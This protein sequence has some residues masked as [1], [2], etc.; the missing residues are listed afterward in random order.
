[1]RFVG[2]HFAEIYTKKRA[3]RRAQSDCSRLPVCIAILMLT[4]FSMWLLQSDCTV[5]F[6]CVHVCVR[7]CAIQ[8]QFYIIPLVAALQLH[9]K[10]RDS[11]FA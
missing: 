9:L 3:S 4:A 7:A 8:A 5:Y 11:R 10:S 6:V 1:M 2:L